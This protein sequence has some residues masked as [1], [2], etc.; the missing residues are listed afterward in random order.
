MEDKF[1]KLSNQ[2]HVDLKDAWELIYKS[3]KNIYIAKELA[4]QKEG[5]VPTEEVYDELIRG[6]EQSI[7]MVHY[8]YKFFEK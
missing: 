2:I 3:L 5:K 7:D 4:V 6:L 1:N 8:G